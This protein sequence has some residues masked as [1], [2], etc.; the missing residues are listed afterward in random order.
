MTEWSFILPCNRSLNGAGCFEFKWGRN[1][2]ASTHLLK[3]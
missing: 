3:E 1:D 2:L